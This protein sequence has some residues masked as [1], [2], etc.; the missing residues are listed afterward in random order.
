MLAHKTTKNFICVLVFFIGTFTETICQTTD[1]KLVI[2]LYSG[3]GEHSIKKGNRIIYKLNYTQGL[4]RAKISNITAD[5]I[6]LSNHTKVPL[7]YISE[8]GYYSKQ[9]KTIK[10]VGVGIVLLSGVLAWQFAK[11]FT[12]SSNFTTKVGGLSSAIVTAG[13]GTAMICLKLR[14]YKIPNPWQIQTSKEVKGGFIYK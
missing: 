5:T 9:D 1:S 7:R 14:L 2:K 3:F 4:K 6:M 12:P 10:K 8:I 13:I 11:E